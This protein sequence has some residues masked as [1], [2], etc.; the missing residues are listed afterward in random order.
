M[1]LV[2][3]ATDNAALNRAVSKTCKARNIPVNVVDDRENC[4]F[5]FP[6]LVQQG[7]LS[8]GI[9]TGGASPTA[10][11]WLKNRVNEL[12]PADFDEILSWLESMRPRLKSEIPEETHRAA[13]LSA[14]FSNCLEKGRPLTE[15]ELAALMEG[16]T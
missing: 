16:Q 12:L 13:L 3:A 1:A 4:T 14:L 10:A 15:A 2:I 11:V 5:L 6:C 9:S 8:V 7:E